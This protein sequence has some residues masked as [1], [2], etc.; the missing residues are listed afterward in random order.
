M[1]LPRKRV[2]TADEVRALGVS[3][4]VTTAAEI[5]GIGRTAAYEAARTGTFPVPVV[6]FGSR[7]VVPVTPLLRLLGIDGEQS[8]GDDTRDG[9]GNGD[10]AARGPE[11]GEAARPAPETGRREHAA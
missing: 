11:R 7:F 5:L 1:M 6:R 8:R 9:D 10:R 3:T 4:D 2:W